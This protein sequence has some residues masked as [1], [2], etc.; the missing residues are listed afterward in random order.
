[1]ESK[2]GNTSD[3]SVGELAL[4]RVGSHGGGGFD[5]GLGR[6]FLMP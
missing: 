2:R 5:L 4:C 3:T 1:M 6:A